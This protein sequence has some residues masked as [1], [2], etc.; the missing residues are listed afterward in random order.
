M[1][2]TPFTPNLSQLYFSTV[3]QTYAFLPNLIG[4]L[5][6]LLIGSLLAK[7][8]KNLV[9][10][11]LEF[12]HIS[13]AIKNTPV[14]EFVKHATVGKTIEGIAASL[15]YWL[16]ML[17]VLQ[18]VASILGLSSLALLLERVVAYIPRIVAAIMVLFFGVLVAGILES[19][20][21]GSIRSIN[22]RHSRLL[23]KVAS[24]L[25]LS[26][27]ILIAVSE[28]GIAQQFIM[29]LFVGLVATLT[30]SLGL[31]IGLGGKE[32]M[33]KIIEEWYTTMKKE[34]KD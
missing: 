31:S 20:V 1:D 29:I 30:L 26:L 2:L 15:V 25:T 4:A 17:L 24:Y 16:L 28:L 6:V 9:K 18:T 7:W 11:S 33:G 10:R 27:F 12:L 8:I 34:I 21:K 14:E 3:A 5:L 32:V 23:G 22:G 13:E 19:L